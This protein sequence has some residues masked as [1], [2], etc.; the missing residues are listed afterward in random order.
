VTELRSSV[1]GRKHEQSK[2]ETRG[3]KRLRHGVS[4][5]DQKTR[6]VSGTGM[7]ITP[8]LRYL[9]R[10]GRFRTVYKMKAGDMTIL[11]YQFS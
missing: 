3:I 9:R 1:V 6:Q 8:Q 7:R 4:D 5:L 11:R 2:L 10:E